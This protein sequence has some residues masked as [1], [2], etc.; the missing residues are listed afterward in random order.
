M[1]RVMSRSR[2]WTNSRVSSS[3]A[4]IVPSRNAVSGMTLVVVPDSMWVT[5]TTAG[6]NPVDLRRDGFTGLLGE[7]QCIHVGS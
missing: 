1:V 2:P 6:E 3:K 4:R 7:R 5:L